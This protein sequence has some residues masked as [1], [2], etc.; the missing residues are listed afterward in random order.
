MLTCEV[1]NVLCII[2]RISSKYVDIDPDTILK[3][4]AN[5]CRWKHRLFGLVLHSDIV[6]FILH[7]RSLWMVWGKIWASY[8]GNGEHNFVRD[9]LQATGAW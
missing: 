7:T 9:E 1:K 3:K 4:Q 6:H 8:A 2:S 5:K